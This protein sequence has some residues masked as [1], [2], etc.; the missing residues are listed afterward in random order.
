MLEIHDRRTFES[1]YSGKAAWDIGR[2]QKAFI[3]NVDQV[4]GSVLD[5]GCGTGENALFFA[6]RD[7]PVIGIDFLEFPIQEAQSEN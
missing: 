3:E 1:M 5:A 7:H 2:P 6:Q 4:Q